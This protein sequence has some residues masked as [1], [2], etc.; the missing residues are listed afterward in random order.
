[1]TP[2][3]LRVSVF[4]LL[5][6]CSQFV[7]SSS[8]VA[9]EDAT[10]YA[11]PIASPTAVQQ[12]PSWI[13]LGPNDVIIARA[14]RTETCPQITIDG[15]TGTM[16]IRALPNAEHPN[17]VC[18]TAVPSGSKSVSIDGQSMPLPVAEPQ[19]IA[20][21]G[22]TGCRLK[23]P[24]SY[25]ACNDPAQ[26]PFAT[27]AATSTRWDPDLV[28][29]VG[30]YL[31]RESPCPADNAGCAGSPY[32]DTWD[33][34]NA[35]FFQ[36]AAPLLAAAP[37]I[38]VRGNHEDCTR[39]GMG[40]FRYLDPMPMP[41]TCQPYTEP[42]ALTIGNVRAVVLDVASAQDTTATPEV[43]A[44]YVPIFA[45]ALELAGDGPSWL[46]TH[47]PLWSIGADGSG[48]P[49]EW[50]TATYDQAGFSQ[51]SAVWDLVVAGHVHMSQLLW[52]TP[53]SQRAPQ[54]IA[55][56]GGTELDDMATGFFD[57]SNL[58]DKDLVQG[59]RW[60]EFGF[61]TIQPVDTG[62]VAGVRLIDA[63]S[64][65]TCLS[66]GPELACLPS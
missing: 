18:E 37:W 16:N 41:T 51:K 59:W 57:G 23:G 31:Y 45:K 55:G 61:M 63:P 58:G 6:L 25:Q 20:L 50:S 54:L 1:M 64:P 46:L 65:A 35:D 12:W 4:A 36:P 5:V 33:T 43:T 24:D 42:Y 32:G 56:D 17:V 27:T 60:Q 13:A 2:R 53:E 22:D 21:I 10:P 48:K 7:A 66:V 52:F 44:A 30:D 8:A 14:V 15:S 19:R 39:E 49:I 29:H 47:R 34:W 28:I 62:F 11:S 9:A 40:W 38:L 3:S 26:W